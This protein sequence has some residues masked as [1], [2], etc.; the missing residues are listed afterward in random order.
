MARRRLSKREKEV[1]FLLAQGKTN[2][3]IAFEL[4]ISVSSVKT[5]TRRLYFKLGVLSRA[6]ASRLYGELSTKG[7]LDCGMQTE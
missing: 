7:G 5:Y 6:E 4:H 3:E 1:W 2:K